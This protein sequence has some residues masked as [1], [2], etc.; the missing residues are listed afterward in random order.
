MDLEE[1]DLGQRG[2]LYS[3]TIVRVPPAG[4]PGEVPYVLG[5]V[6]LPAGPQVLAQVVD[7]GYD[8]LEIGMTVEL[9]VH[10]VPS[11]NGGPDKLVY[12]WRPAAG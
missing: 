3:Y 2:T 7:C 10:A 6:E 5:Q 1:V 12:K 8:E 4:W 11:H 9:T